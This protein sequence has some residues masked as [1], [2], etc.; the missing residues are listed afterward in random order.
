MKTSYFI[1]ALLAF[2]IAGLQAQTLNNANQATVPPPTAPQVVAAGANERV[3]AWQSYEAAPDGSIRSH[4]N[5]FKELATGL[6]YFSNGQWL[7]SKEE[8]DISPDGKS[9]VAVNGQHQAYFPAEIYNGVIE[10]VTPDGQHLKSRPLGL[11]YDDGHNTVLIAQL[12]N[13]VGYV[14]GSNQVIYSNAFTGFRADLLYQYTKMGFEQDVIIRQQPPAPEAFN[15]IS[16]NTR[17]QLL[18]E[19]FNSPVPAVRTTILPEQGGMTLY[20]AQLDFGLM[21]M[22]LGRAFLLGAD[23]HDG[24][25]LVSK[26]WEV[27]EGRQFLVEEVPVPALAEELQALPLQASAAKPGPAMAGRRLPAQHQAGNKSTGRFL[28][29]ARA[30]SAAGLVMDY[31]T[32]NTSQTNYTFQADFT[33]YI[34]GNVSLNGTNSTFEGGTV[35]KDAANVTLTVN[36]PVTWKGTNY[37]P[38]IVTAKDDNS[39][40][41]SLPGGTGTPTG[42]Y[43]VTGLAYNA[44]TANANLVL[45]NLRVSYAQTAVSINGGSGHVLND[46]QF[47]SCANGLTLTNTAFSLYNALFSNV[48]TNFSGSSATGDVEQV[49][50][51]TASWFNSNLGS[52]LYLTNCL[53]VGVTNLGILSNTNSVSI[54]SGSGIFQV[55]GAASHYLATNSSYHS[56]GT[57]YINPALLTRLSQ[58]TTYP[59]I[60]YSNA[61]LSA[62]TVFS[63]QAERDTNSSLDLGYHYDPIDYAF[64]G[65][66]ASSNVTFNAGTAVAWFVQSAGSYGLIAGAN[67]TAAFN[68]TATAPC[69]FVRYSNVQEGG[70]GNWTTEGY[71][72]GLASGANTAKVVAQFTRCCSMPYSE[73]FFRDDSGGLTI[74]VNECEFYTASLAG[75]GMVMNMTNCLFDRVY[76]LG[77]D[78]CGAITPSFSMRN[79]TMHGGNMN[80]WH[81][82]NAYWP[83]WIENC[84]F[85]GTG[86][87]YMDNN[88]GGNTNIT[89]CDFNAFLSGSNRLVVLGAHDVIVT[90]SFNWQTSW[91]GN[92]YLPPNSPLINAGSVTADVVGLYHYTTQ[93]NQMPETNSIVDIGYHYVATDSYGN[94]LDTNGDGIADYLEDANGNGIFDAGDL[95]EW[96]ISP[97]G[98][99]GNNALQVFTPL[100]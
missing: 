97:F 8:I 83:V 94:P 18:T 65:T 66:S 30:G 10:L 36:T 64:G 4:L 48:L 39:V 78:D 21:R 40:G 26:S 54:A 23:A 11:S 92:Y 5:N 91:F 50:V 100:K 88:A 34:T 99:N 90:N 16:Q 6:N 14:V 7:A 74:T 69:W 59:P 29:L 60:V 72:G 85:D 76:W 3:W 96:K 82:C 56:A 12:T 89:Y 44:V 84:T 35:I 15:M 49:T 9:A 31:I 67:V 25:V 98:L 32:A 43:G 87:T 42:Y 41:Q 17:L 93:T 47:F 70:N 22:V 45:Q 33:Y 79:C 71:V 81:S 20:D 75:Y 77:P 1:V 55:A 19:F 52:N 62:A 51:D 86:T 37:R 73:N 61:T 46:V 38:V 68:G 58:K 24:G 27:L 63:P 28:R 53:L 2:G 95:G 57:T 80:I 13:A